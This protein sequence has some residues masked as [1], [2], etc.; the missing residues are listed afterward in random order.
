[1]W[2][3]SSREVGGSWCG[4]FLSVCFVGSPFSMKPHPENTGKIGGKSLISIWFL[5]SLIGNYILWEIIVVVHTYDGSMGCF[6]MKKEGIPCVPRICI[7][8]Q[9]QGAELPH[10]TDRFTGRICNVKFMGVLV[11]AH[12]HPAWETTTITN[13]DDFPTNAV[14]LQAIHSQERYERE[15]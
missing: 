8:F 4:V 6:V 1:M 14:S 15:V 11:P 2:V 3:N 7:G 5:I 12:D 9:V 10:G 13:V